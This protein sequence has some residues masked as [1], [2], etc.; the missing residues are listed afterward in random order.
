V[1]SGLGLT[2]GPITNSGT[3]SVDTKAV[4]LL[5]SAN[6][7]TTLQQITVSSGNTDGLEVVASAPAF[8]AI[9]ALSNATS[10]S[11]AGVLGGS[12]SPS[13]YGVYGSNSASGG[14]GVY[15]TT[16]GGHA[17][18]GNDS[19]GG[20]GVVGTGLIGVYGTSLSG[21][22]G[23]EGASTS[24]YGVFG[25]GQWG[26]YGTSTTCCSGSGGTF[27][28]YNAPSGSGNSGTD[29]VSAT[30]GT[31]DNQAVVGGGNG[32]GG[33]G[34]DG[35]FPGSGGSFLGGNSL[36]SSGPGG[37]GVFSQGGNGAG[38]GRNG[39]AGDFFGDLNVSG[40]ITAG[41]KDFKIDH[42]LDPANKYLVHASVESSDMMNMYTGNAITDTQG[43]AT[44]KL[45]E[46]FETLNT[47]FRYQLTVIGQFAQ[48]IISHEIQ[49][50]QFSIRT[51]APNVKVSWQVTG[52]RQD[53]FAKAHPLVVEEEKDARTKGFYIHPDLYGAPQEKQIEWVRHPEM[54]KRVAEQREA[55]R[56]PALV[57]TLPAVKQAPSLPL[58]AQRILK[59]KQ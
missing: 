16:S 52:V 29:G 15:G 41:T 51:N 33:T 21:D 57:P 24:G 46:W 32:V 42:P 34:G 12:N 25:G 23:V 49:N 55:P 11:A 9:L 53:A 40:A 45:P 54:M 36:A 20:F 59:K 1:G 27:F 2:G 39:Y 38:G 47:D 14:T 4:P 10:G 7:F 31:G 28:G 22:A 6:V 58:A 3:L 44:V 48:A 56:L 43:L 26:V 37:D 5:G 18:V 13:G 19:G 35:I 8:G 17:V 30:G 50:H